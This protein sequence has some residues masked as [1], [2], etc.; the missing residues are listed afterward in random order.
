MIK[1]AISCGKGVV[2]EK[3][4][5]MTLAEYNALLELENA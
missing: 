2:C 3:P 1:K 5:T 4:V